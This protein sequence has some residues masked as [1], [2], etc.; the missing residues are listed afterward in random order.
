MLHLA[1][2][3]N[4][5][6]GDVC[7]LWP[8]AAGR[9]PG[10]VGVGRPE[11]P[12]GEERSFDRWSSILNEP[13]TIITDVTV[14][15][16]FIYRPRP[17]K[18][19]PANGTTMLV[20]PGGGYHDLYMELEGEEVAEWLNSQ[21]MTGIVMK[22]RVPR[23]ATDER[24]Q[25]PLGPLIDA[26]RALSL[27]RHNAADWGIDPER[28]GI[29]GFSAGGHLAVSLATRFEK[30]EYDTV[31]AAD[32]R[33]CRPDFAVACYPGYLCEPMTEVG[34][35]A[36]GGF[37]LHPSMENLPRDIPP[38][39]LTHASDDGTAVGGSM[40]ENSAV[41]Y[42]ALRAA[43]VLAELHIWASG[44]HDFGVRSNGQLPESWTNLCVRW[45]R[46]RGLLQRA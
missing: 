4:L 32:D 9:G 17:H 5:A 26:Q 13:T 27:A 33:S 30:R 12:F 15:Q 31:D 29:V 3:S 40:P 8:T 28:I 34:R 1:A 37:S 19:P 39:F 20:A 36:H 43:G 45:L 38:V 2:R 24:G 44:D 35:E 25:P 23:R 7:N 21:G 6:A 46:S 16:L 11:R 22:Y 10:D 18:H 14:P 42:L 41:M